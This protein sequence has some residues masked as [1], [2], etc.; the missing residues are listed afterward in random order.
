[1]VLVEGVGV[2]FGFISSVRL[3]ERFRDL[4]AVLIAWP[5]MDWLAWDFG[6][7]GYGFKAFFL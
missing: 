3:D 7:E 1:M 4:E 6:F 5:D 2:R